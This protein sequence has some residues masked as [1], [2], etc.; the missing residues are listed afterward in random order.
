[1]LRVYLNAVEIMTWC[2]LLREVVLATPRQ[3]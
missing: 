3:L 2:A 1:M